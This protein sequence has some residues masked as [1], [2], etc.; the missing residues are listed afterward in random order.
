MFFIFTQNNLSIKLLYYGIMYHRSPKN[1]Q[2]DAKISISL[3][4]HTK[5]PPDNIES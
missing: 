2:V 4:R 3:V 5:S 1:A